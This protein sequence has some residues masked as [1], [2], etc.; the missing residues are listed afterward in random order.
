MQPR[1][2][3]VR[4]RRPAQLRISARQERLMITA[5]LMKGLRA[6]LAAARGRMVTQGDLARDLGI[7]PRA[8]MYSEDPNYRGIRRRRDLYA[9]L[10]LI[11]EAK[12]VP[13]LEKNR[14]AYGQPKI[15]PALLKLLTAPVPT[16]PP[17]EGA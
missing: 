16:A 3:A 17:A 8:V 2:K 6:E 12:A 1:R 15:R 13:A 4:Q 5:D 9:I 10:W 14:A 7:A 11:A